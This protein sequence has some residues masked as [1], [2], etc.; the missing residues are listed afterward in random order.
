MKAAST[1]LALIVVCACTQTGKK[2]DYFGQTPAGTTSVPFAPGIVSTE[3]N[4]H[5]S[6]AFAPD[7][8]A[9]LWAVMDR[10]YRGRLLE[11]KFSNGQWSEPATP[12]FADTIADYYAPSFSPDGKTLLFSS[13]RKVPGYR[14]GRGNRIWSVEKTTSGWGAPVP[15]DTT[16]SKGEEFSHSIARSGTLYFSSAAGSVGTSLNILASTNDDGRRWEPLLLP[17]NINTPGYEDGPFI[18]PDEDYLIFESTRPDGVQGSHDLYISFRT[19]DGEWGMPVNMGPSVNSG[20][21]E[22]FPRVTPDGKY[23]VFA[24][25]RDQ[26]ASRAGF[27]FYW[28]DAKVIDD[29][30]QKSSSTEAIQ[31]SPD[32]D[33][34]TAIH[35]GD[36]TRLDQSLKQWLQTHPESLDAV[37]LYSS[38]LRNQKRFSEAEQLTAT[39]SASNN[40]SLIIET[41][42]VKFGLNKDKD[43]EQLLAPVLSGSADMRQRYL[44]LSTALF[45]MH[46]F[47]SS[48]EYFG[49]AM[50]IEANGLQYYNRA[51]DYAHLGETVRV[52][53]NLNKAADLGYNS[54]QQYKDDPDLAGVRQDKRYRTLMQKLK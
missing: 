43:A 22:R 1:I 38:V 42:L 33:I 17:Y 32:D 41:A 35:S 52:F 27:D 48:D 39:I 31:Q 8:S 11:M 20:A 44:E 15:F 6:L 50:A 51:C 23:L 54:R 49:K 3:A 53:E 4:E 24:S 25:N 16:V 30:K 9:V 10:Q 14:E 12:S 13:R 21:M 46:K 28:I 26:S 5:S 34:L 19:G 18:S 7:G 36:S 47:D 29:L 45:E 37:V 2:I 40:E